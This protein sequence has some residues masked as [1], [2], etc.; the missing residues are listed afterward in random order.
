LRQGFNLDETSR[1]RRGLGI[2]APILVDALRRLGRNDEAASFINRAATIAPNEPAIRRLAA[3]DSHERAAHNEPGIKLTGRIKRL[4]EPL[5]KTP[6]GF[7][8]S[9][10][11]AND[12]YFSQRQIG[13]DVFSALSVGTIVEADVVTLPD[14]RRQ[15]RALRV[16]G[17]I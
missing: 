5:G 8:T 1:N 11:D 3:A 4:L 10:V 15:A 17:C 2:V 9:D 13:S 12:V 7:F 14:G 16:I 6:F